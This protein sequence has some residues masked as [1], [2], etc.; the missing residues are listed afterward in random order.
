METLPAIIPPFKTDYTYSVEGRGILRTS[1]TSG[2]VRQR[3]RVISNDD[4]CN[5]VLMLTDLQLRVF[6]YFVKIKLHHGA[7]WFNGYHWD[8]R[9][10][11]ARVLRL[12]GGSYEVAY[13]APHYWNVS[14]VI[15]VRDRSL[16]D[17]LYA[18]FVLGF[19]A[20]D[21]TRYDFCSLFDHLANT[22]N[23]NN[24]IVDPVDPVDPF[25]PNAFNPATEALDPIYI[26]LDNTVNNNDLNGVVR[27][28]VDPVDPDPDP[29]PAFD[30]ATSEMGD[31][32]VRLDN[33]VNNNNLAA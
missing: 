20:I 24:L 1:M 32:Y 17:D 28:P 10:K 31:R 25:D 29:D 26:R 30:P 3:R 15:D 12:Q 33:T 9:R 18:E 8:G 27:G 21:P 13:V 5:V 2:A 22:V 4:V 7:D 11:N 19:T 14:M 23:N 16:A 6:E